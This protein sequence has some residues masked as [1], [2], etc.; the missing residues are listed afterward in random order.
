[1]VNQPNCTTKID[2]RPCN[3]LKTA[4]TNTDIQVRIT[5]SQLTYSTIFDSDKQNSEYLYTFFPKT[6]LKLDYTLA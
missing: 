4:P 6:K 1:M 3:L 2:Y 5:T